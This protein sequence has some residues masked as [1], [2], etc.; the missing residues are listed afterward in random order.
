MLRRMWTVYSRVL[1]ESFAGSI[2]QDEAD[3]I[4]TALDRVRAAARNPS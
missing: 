1:R 2:D 4:A 3:V